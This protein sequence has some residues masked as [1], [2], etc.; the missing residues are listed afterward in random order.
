MRYSWMSVASIALVIAAQAVAAQREVQYGNIPSWVVPSPAATNSPAPPGAPLRVVYRDI[1][2]HLGPGGDEIFDSYRLKIL[3]PEGLKAGNISV[4]WSP[5]A[6]NAT[7]HYIRIIRDNQVIDVLKST[8]F[9]ILQREGALELSILDGQLTAALQAPGLQVGD[10]LEIAV[11]TRRKDLTLGDHSFGFAQ[12]PATGMPGAFRIRMIWPKNREMIWRTSMDVP[13]LS[14]TVVQGQEELLYELRDPSSAVLADGAPVRVNVRRLI[15]YSDFKSWSEVSARIW[16]LFE[17]ASKLT[18]DSPIRKETARIAAANSDPEKRIEAALQL[19]QDRVR[20]V[21]IGLNGG[22]FTPASADETWERRFGDCKAK[23]ALLLAVLRELGIRGEAALVN[24]SGGD[25]TNERLP[26]PGAF[27]HVL[28][29]ATVGG[30]SYWLDGSRL[31]DKAVSLIPP[32]KFR[33]ALP[34]R[35]GGSELENVPASPPTMP[36]SITAL[37]VDATA[38]FDQKATIKVQ[39]VLRGDVALQ[40]RSQLLA[41]SA[42]DADRA[43]KAFW[44]NSDGW[45]DPDSVSWRYDEQRAT[46]L[47][48][49]TGKGK[50]D[51]TK[52]NDSEGR[53]LSIFGAGFTPPNEFRRSREQDQAAPWTREFPAYRCWVTAIHLPSASS[54]LRWDYSSEPMNTQMGGVAYWRA[55]DLR[56]NVVRTA[57]SRRSVIP[58]IT[59]AQAE[60]VNRQLPTFNN[61]MSTVYEISPGHELIHE[62]TPAPPFQPDTDWS[63]PNAPCGP[64]AK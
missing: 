57:M 22:N 42:E 34:L 13:K 39:Q 2:I 24:S 48:S 32:P 21:Y 1:Q 64:P 4:S 30:T 16:P 58:E 49:L 11:T 29:R 53:S 37:D 35:S 52:G 17:K 45:I 10:E 5:D 19:V 60:E 12:L 46:V 43:L 51:W 3:K 41:L 31:G 25:G 47:L 61:N 26:T 20:Y 27:D 59:A 15:E 18:P 28:V 40:I 8:K 55:S 54:G 63:S 6:G 62:A 38:G 33:W 7:V 36:D 44:N 14:T 56:D 9:E 23:T 50:L